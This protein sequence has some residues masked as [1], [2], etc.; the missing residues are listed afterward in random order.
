[1]EVNMFNELKNILGILEIICV[2]ERLGHTGNVADHLNYLF[3]RY[4][5]KDF[6]KL[7]KFIEDL[8]NEKKKRTNRS[9]SKR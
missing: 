1:M 8:E 9:R 4:N 3:K 2:D 5:E 6:E 7:I